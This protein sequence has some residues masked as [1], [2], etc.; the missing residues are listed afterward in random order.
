MQAAIR[1]I[2]GATTAAMLLTQTGC[3][4]YAAYQHNKKNVQVRKAR[5][6]G[7]DAAIKAFNN[8]DT[9]GIGIDI[10]NW[11]VLKEGPLLQTAAAIADA[12]AAY[13]V[14]EG[15]DGF[16]QR[17]IIVVNNSGDGTVNITINHTS[18]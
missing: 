3:F 13:T 4:S 1:F 9:V 16:N 5:L 6:M 2:L 15:L 8:G 14:K 18:Y 7:N 12:A 11:E 17:Q 10:S